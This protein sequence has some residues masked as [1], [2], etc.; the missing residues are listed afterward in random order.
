MLYFP[1]TNY[2]AGKLKVTGEGSIKVRPDTA[3]AILGVITENSQL[4]LAQEQNTI[5]VNQILNT[6]RMMMVSM[7]DIETQAYN[8]SPQYDYVDGKQVFR[9]YRVEH[10]LKIVVK[11]ITKVGEV[12]DGAVESGANIVNSIRFI[13]SEPSK[14]YQKALTAAIDDALLKAM[15]IG[16][17]FNIKIFHIPLVITEQNY[18][19]SSPV[20]SVLLQAAE[21]TTP[22]QVGQI[23]ITARIEAVFTYTL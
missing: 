13:A 7:N 14:Y 10:T 8:I 18:Q 15:T 20:Q 3:L 19:Y 17:K 22:I 21:S 16:R 9:G 23:D 2:C 1:F 11:D 6:L 5:K 4:R 12:I